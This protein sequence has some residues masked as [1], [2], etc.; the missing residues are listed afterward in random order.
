MLLPK[1]VLP[2]IAL[3]FIISSQTSF[4]HDG[5]DEQDM[6]VTKL[7]NLG[8]V[9]FAVSCSADSQKAMNTGV[10]LLHHM[11]YAQAEVFFDRWIK[12]SP[13][14]AMLYWGYSMTLFHPLWPDTITEEALVRGEK[15]LAKSRQL[16]V[17]AREN[18]YIKAAS[19]YYENWSQ[20]SEQ[21]RIKAWAKA[22]QRVFANNANDVDAI[23]LHALSLLV[24]ADK[25]DVSFAQ[26]K[27]AGKLLDNIFKQASTHPG[28]IHYSIHAYDNP[29]LAELGIEKA[30]AY[31]Q[32]APDVPHALHMPSHV[33]VRLGMWPDVISWNSRS[34]KAALKYPTKGATSMHYIHAIDYLLYGHL[35]ENNDAAARKVVASIAEHHPIQ[36]TFPAAYALTTIPARLALENHQWRQASQLKLRTPS[37]FNWDK[38]PE[39]EAISYFSRGVGAARSGDLNAAN[40]N[41]K[42][43]D[44]LH[45]KVMKTSPSYWAVLVDAQRKTV[46]AWI[47]YAQGNKAQAIALLK[48]AADMED[49]MD[50]NPVTPG[51]VIPVRELL[52]DMYMLNSNYA[53]ALKAYQLCL[54]INP[55]RL[56]SVSGTTLARQKIKDKR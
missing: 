41:L 48:N 9:D 30:R 51:A 29:V 8:K 28:A 24:T 1:G 25:K 52:A 17:S 40:E 34:A 15:A 5:H 55:Q 6:T 35:Q 37:Y 7:G 56:N 46:A 38:F 50:K 11:M 53:A 54:Q 33:F 43:L 18:D 23:A 22:Q 12:K 27:Q 31:D 10:A 21:T 2:F 26:Q 16:K 36:A 14:C 19:A 44:I 49:A 42:M 47:N 20:Q 45:H 39:V 13:E 3:L 4:A 32:I